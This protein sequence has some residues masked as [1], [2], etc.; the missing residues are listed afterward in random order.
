M[1]FFASKKLYVNRAADNMQAFDTE[2][3]KIYKS[4]KMGKTNRTKSSFRLKMRLSQKKHGNRV[5]PGK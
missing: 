5:T 2:R 3:L 1:L 4:V